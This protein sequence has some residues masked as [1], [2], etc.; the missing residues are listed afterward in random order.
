MKLS[1]VPSK[2]SESYLIQR[3]TSENKFERMPPANR[4]L[5]TPEEIR[6]LRMWIDQGADW[7]EKTD[8]QLQINYS[9]RTWLGS[10]STQ[11]LPQWYRTP[12]NGCAWTCD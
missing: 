7:P 11:F 12:F 6:L 4:D 9:R 3:I 5:V 10:Y 1:I 2:S 8:T